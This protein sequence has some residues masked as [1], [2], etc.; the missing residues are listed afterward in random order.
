MD[1][2]PPTEKLDII[3]IPDPMP[4][5]AFSE[6]NRLNTQILS[7]YDDPKDLIHALGP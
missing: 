2:L 6:L 5:S 4:A 7:A 1:F 3:L